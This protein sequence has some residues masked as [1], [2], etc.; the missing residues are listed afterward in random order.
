MYE[1]SNKYGSVFFEVTD[2]LD[3]KYA[4]LSFVLAG[5]DI[6]ALVMVLSPI[7]GDCLVK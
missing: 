4:G 6:L 7:D 1:Y 3:I 2:M 5:V